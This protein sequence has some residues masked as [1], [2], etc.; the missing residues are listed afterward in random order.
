[1]SVLFSIYC[2][3]SKA[4]LSESFKNLYLYINRRTYKDC[5][6]IFFISKIRNYILLWNL[7]YLLFPLTILTLDH[8]TLNSSSGNTDFSFSSWKGCLMFS[9]RPW[10][11]L[12]GFGDSCRFRWFLDICHHIFFV[13][14]MWCV[15]R[16]GTIC[17]I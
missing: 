3:D 4:Y 1:M 11:F 14:N 8:I 6:F 17:T 16:F 10:N 15:A 9:G 2:I 7:A 5:I 12:T 13:T